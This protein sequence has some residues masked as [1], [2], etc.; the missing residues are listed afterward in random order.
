MRFHNGIRQ[1]RV[2][3][4]LIELLVVIAI[5][6]I[7]IALLLPAVQQA[8]EAARRSQCKNNLK[9]MALAMHNY[10]ATHSVL[11]LTSFNLGSNPAPGTRHTGFSPQAQILPYLEQ[12]NLYDLIDFDE[13]LL[14]VA[15]PPWATNLNTVHEVA[16]RTRVDTF[17]CPS[18]PAQVLF[19]DGG[20]LY[21][22]HN[23]MVNL[24]SGRVRSYYDSAPD[25]ADLCDGLFYRGS[26][27]KFRDITDGLSNTVLLAE[28][29]GG[30]KVG[31][32]P[33]ATA[34]TDVRTQM[35]RV[36]SD[37]P[38]GPLADDL[39]ALPFDSADG[40]RGGSWIRGLGYFVYV[41][42]FRGPNSPEPDV[43]NHGNGLVTPRS[44]HTGG[45]NLALADGSVRFV[46]DSVDL[47][48]FRNAFAR[49]DGQVMGE[50]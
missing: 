44:Y 45:A 36:D 24:G 12:A 2:G 41:T 16:A 42:G 13:P 20:T 25:P 33:G 11:P 30:A 5:I 31:S 26:R 21:A 9:Q 37:P 23:Y 8:R 4:T 47:E 7:L 39:W 15:L 49:D 19:D 40:R 29:T 14:N 32:I 22:G 6:A 10:H 38:G 1:S 28:T 46:S 43:A 3:F 48:T 17:L 18:D 27:I 35:K 50:F 34:V